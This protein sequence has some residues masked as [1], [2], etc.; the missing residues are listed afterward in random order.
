[1]EV[2]V[3]KRTATVLVVEDNDDTRAVLAECL[4]ME[5]YRVVPAADLDTALAL[6][7]AVKVGA[8]V[9][10]AAMTGSW[11]PADVWGAPERLRAA[12]PGVPIIV[13][14]AHNAE[15]FAGYAGRGFAAFVPKPF[16]LDDLLG[17]VACCLA[18][19]QRG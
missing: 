13:C 11:Q 4:G 16:D 10:D 7:A 17:A 19:D 15:L 3:D 14:S 5:G 2:V 9:T 18:T 12:A 6:L 8:V 1:L